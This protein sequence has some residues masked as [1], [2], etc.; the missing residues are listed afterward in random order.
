M[1]AAFIQ[2]VLPQISL[3]SAVNMDTMDPRRAPVTPATATLSAAYL[4]SVTRRADSANVLGLESPA[5]TARS[6]KPGML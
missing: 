2:Q 5:G 4:I 3:Q 6:A 1:A